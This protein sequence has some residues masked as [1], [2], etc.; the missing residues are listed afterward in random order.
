[1]RQFRIKGITET[2]VINIYKSKIVDELRNS[3]Y[4]A[5][6]IQKRG[7]G[8]IYNISNADE[9]LEF[10]KLLDEGTITEQEFER[11]KNELLQ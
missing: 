6:E 11:K 10:K 1:M 8:N 5:Q 7:N 9:I 2:F 4:K 3:I